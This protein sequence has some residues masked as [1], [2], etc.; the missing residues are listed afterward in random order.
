M[1]SLARLRTQAGSAAIPIYKFQHIENVQKG[2]QHLYNCVNIM[3]VYQKLHFMKAQ[4]NLMQRVKKF[5]SPSNLLTRFIALE[6]EICIESR[7][8]VNKFNLQ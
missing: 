2:M 8:L 5:F 7:L 4:P 6:V 3:H 1:P